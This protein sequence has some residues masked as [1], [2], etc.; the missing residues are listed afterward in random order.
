M[1]ATAR[2]LALAL[3]PVLTST[4]VADS[5]YALTIANQ[6]LVAD[7]AVPQKVVSSVNVTGLNVGESLLGIDVRPANGQ[8]YALSDGA[9]LFTI[10][11]ATGLATL[12][13]ALA[14]DP[15]DLTSPFTGLTGTNFAIDFNPVADRLRV[16]SNTEQNLRINP[17]NG[18]VTTDTALDYATGDVNDTANP[19]VAT[20]AYAPN[21][22]G[23]TTLF[24][25][26][27]TTFRVVTINPPNNGTLIS[28]PAFGGTAATH[29]G[30]DIGP[31]GQVFVAGRHDIPGQ[32]TEW[33]LATLNTV[34]GENE[35]HGQ[36][37]DGTIPI[38]DIAIAPA[39]EFSADQFAVAENAGIATITVRRSGEVSQP[40][41]VQYTTLSGTASAGS[42]YATA[43]G[44]LSFAGTEV[45]K[46]FQVT[47]INDVFP[48]GDEFVHLT[49]T[50]VTGAGVLGSPS[51]ATLRINSN[52]RTDVNGPQITFIGLTG[53]SRGID[54]AVVHFDED[55][56]PATAENLENY[57]LIAVPRRGHTQRVGVTSAVYDPVGRT[58][59]LQ[60]PAFEQTDFRRTAVR[61]NGKSGG[62][63]DLAGNLLDGNRNGRPGGN[64][65]QLFK[66]FSGETVTVRD[67]DGDR[68][69]LTIENGGHIDGVRPVGGPSTQDIQF[70]IVDPISLVSVTSGTVKRSRRGDGL[71]VIAEIIGLDK[72]AFQPLVTN[73]SIVVNRLTFSPDATGLR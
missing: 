52:D 27:D 13:A 10:N 43:M 44:T 72:E 59:T 70:W 17:A 31:D 49:L 11:P 37:G 32:P 15:A 23:V 57:T 73:Q 1:K 35:S 66:I 28:G 60:V 22:G 56:D 39:I 8:L 3:A 30:F 5:I 48:E 9:R 2:L 53:P 47:I 46:T 36:I 34:T 21:V 71:L 63:T 6:L 61:V 68:L 65:T 33:V 12:V 50:G 58:V 64:A 55:L 14:A 40:A 54:G 62:V 45:S 25:I 19:N 67:K 38:R 7:A 69:T 16:V 18:L 51:V 41:T 42:D 26:D 20:I 4:A 24:G 29:C